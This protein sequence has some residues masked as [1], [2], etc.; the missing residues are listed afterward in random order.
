M[1]QEAHHA[2]AV[3]EAHIHHAL[4]RQ[5]GAVEERVGGP[6]ATKAAAV[7]PHEHWQF[8]VHGLRRAPHIQVEAVFADVL[9]QAA[10]SCYLPL[11]TCRGKGVG[12][13]RAGPGCGRLRLPPAQL[14]YGWCGEGN[15][16]EYVQAIFLSAFQQ[17]A[18]HLD[19][20]RRSSEGSRAGEQQRQ[21]LAAHACESAAAGTFVL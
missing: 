4:F 3:G 10:V 9:A 12:L 19:G 6:A 20:G 18:L 1:G 5:R 16:A 8:F 14:T 2:D 17:A 7:H 15:T 21:C 11:C 13:A